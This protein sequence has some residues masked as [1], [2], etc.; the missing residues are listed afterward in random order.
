MTLKILVVG[1]Y[2]IFGGRLCELL[3]SDSR[4]TLLVAGRSTHIAQQFCASLPQGAQRSPLV[5]DRNANVE[6]QLQQ[7][8]PDLVID[9]SGPFQDYGSDPYHLVKACIAQGVNYMDFADGSEFVKGIGQ[10][11]ADAK[12]RKLFVLSGVSSFPVLTAAVTRQLSKG[13]E[14]VLSIKGGIAPS[15]FAVVGLNVIRAIAAYAG[16]PLKIVRNG[17]PSIAYGLTDGMRYTISPPGYLPLRSTYFSL[18][19]VPDLSVL[20]ELWPQA[21]D[22]WMGAGPV[23]EVLHR[24]LNVLANLVRLG[25]LPSLKP[26]ARLFHWAVSTLRWGEHRGGMFV[27]IEGALPDG[28]KTLRSWHLLA[29]GDDGPYIPCMALQ[30]LI[31]KAA[32]GNYPPPGA[33]AA[34]GDLELE[35][36]DQLFKVRTIVTGIRETSATATPRSLYQL[37]LRDAFAKLPKPVQVLHQSEGEETWSGRASVTRGKSLI[38]HMACWFFGFPK[39]GEN[40]ELQVRFQRDRSKQVWTRSFNGKTFSSVL[41]AGTGRA[42]GLINERF[43]PF[44][45]DFALVLDGSKLRYVI[46]RWNFMGLPLP[47]VLAPN[48]ECFDCDRDGK[49]GFDIELRQ[50]WVGLIVRYSGYLQATRVMETL[51]AQ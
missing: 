21:Q 15:P 45:F 40:Q 41:K 39:A 2:G 31:L 9:A 37:I 11:D 28:S 47:L 6:Q 48:G 32:E 3:A 42:S 26:F 20:P 12:A 5:F 23:P 10:F 30:A 19:D 22:I 33:R 24:M 4:L 1:G 38:A 27:E 25:L 44:S 43:G 17:G 13:L 14:R 36:Y 50:A 16:K 49:F 8:Q 51:D 29:E 7:I 46:R 35:D 34:S 18:V